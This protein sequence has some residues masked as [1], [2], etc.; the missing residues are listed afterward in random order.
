MPLAARRVF[1]KGGGSAFFTG[2]RAVL[3]RL[4]LS[5][6]AAQILAQ[7]GRQPLFAG[8]GLVLLT[9]VVLFTH[10][11]SH[12]AIARIAQ[13]WLDIAQA[14][15][16]SAR[17]SRGRPHQRARLTHMDAAVAQW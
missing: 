11:Q 3:R 1:G 13:A 12:A 16:N 4:G 8:G 9:H 17:L 6:A 2:L 7:F 14:Q 10:L 15:D 5:F